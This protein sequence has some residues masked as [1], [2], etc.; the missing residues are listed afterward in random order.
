M[1]RYY[2]YYRIADGRFAQI[3]VERLNG[4]PFSQ[5]ETG[6]FYRSDKAAMADMA[7]LNSR[8]A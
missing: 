3:L 6:V 5:T 2:A 7:R 8:A 4:K 1:L